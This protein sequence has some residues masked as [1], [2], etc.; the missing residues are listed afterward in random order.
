[1]SACV[2][3]CVCLDVRQCLYPCLYMCVCVYVCVRVWVCVCVGDCVV[4]TLLVVT[5][6]AATCSTGIQTWGN[7]NVN[8]VDIFTGNCNSNL[9]LVILTY[10]IKY[11][12][13]IRIYHL[14]PIISFFFHHA[15]CY[16]SQPV[17]KHDYME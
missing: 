4:H 13:S 16:M 15:D 6:T 1:M 11:S 3:V 8:L 7:D 17:F 5:D 12:S 10:P 2:Y 14:A 9:I